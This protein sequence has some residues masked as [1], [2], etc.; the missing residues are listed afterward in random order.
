[1][2]WDMLGL[3]V[4]LSCVGFLLLYS[5]AGRQVMPWMLK[6]TLRLGVGMGF[7]WLVG[8]IDI[9]FWLSQAPLLYG[10]CFC[11]LILVELLGFVGM[12]A[13][14]WV[15]CYLFQIQPSELMKLA[16]VLALASFF[17]HLETQ[18]P[19]LK[20]LLLPGLVVLAPAILVL[21]QPDLGTAL[22]LLMT[23]GI[24]FYGAGVPL[25][26]FAATGGLLA[27]LCPLLWKGLKTYQ[28]KRILIFLDPESD[29]RGAGYHILQSKIAIG[30]GG[31]WGKGLHQGSQSYLNFLPEKQTDFIFTL[32]CEEWG[33]AGGLA[34]I[35]LYILLILR[36]YQLALRVKYVFSRLLITGIASILFL[37][38]CINIAM[39]M[40]VLPVV[41][42]PLPLLSYGGTSMLTILIGFGLV[43]G[44]Y[45]QRDTRLSPTL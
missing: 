45:S 3:L 6:Q 1:M 15:D 24:L 21:R 29:P 26:F 18:E 12:G 42:V 40:G 31:L 16:L 11:L 30:S 8:S 25:R 41:G 10:G 35:S 9:R 43:V 44:A 14:R 23:G 33:L 28:Q 27:A 36:C 17:H 5:A 37:H 13:R 34:L 4:L 20:Q 7:L 19:R 38:V 22:I 2:P 39:V 32:L